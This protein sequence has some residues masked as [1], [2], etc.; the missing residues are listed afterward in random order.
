MK[1]FVYE[2]ITSGVFSGQSLPISLATEGDGMLTAILQDLAVFSQLELSILRDSRLAE[3]SDIAHH[4]KLNYNW[5]EN[6]GHFE[7]CWID[8]L[9]QCDAVFIIAPETDNL[10][11]TRQQSVLDHGKMY[12]GSSI[13]ATTMTS[14]KHLCYQQLRANH[15]NTPHTAIATEWTLHDIDYSNGIVI[16]PIDGAGCLDTYLFDEIIDAKNYLDTLTEV[17]KLKL[18][19]QPYIKGLAA[20]LTLF[21][22]P[23][24]ATILSVN[25]Q[26]IKRQQ[27]QLTYAG[28]I[29]GNINSPKATL[30]T[31]ANK[32][33]SAFS[34]LWGF[35]GVDLVFSSSG[36]V[37]IE[38]NPRLT[39]SYIGLKQHIDFNPATLLINTLL[40]SS[41]TTGAVL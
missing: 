27:N 12:L 37:I 25:Q 29:I 8:C 22:T 41:Q 20:S 23:N 10:L 36:P 3:I 31:I 17:V 34:G 7:Q 39:S 19:V 4:G 24:A 5:I 11:V 2:H 28:S 30:Q 40:D 26:H 33:Q 18:I 6:I 15:V 9:H 21:I 13:E 1:L 16:K 38:V 35:V 32:I 14:N